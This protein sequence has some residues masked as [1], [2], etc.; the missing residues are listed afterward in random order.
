VT[1]EVG[2]RYP[3]Q[4]AGLVGISGYAHNPDA[5]SREMSRV[6]RSQR[7]LVTHG[8]Q[9]PLL[10]IE[11]VRG[12]MRRLQAAGLSVEWQEFVKPH[13]IAGEAE[14]EVIRAFLSRCFA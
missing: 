7:F 11:P 1:L 8:T 12:Q 2:V 3:M 13:T 6:A 5:L 14:V 9:D 4:L 10:P